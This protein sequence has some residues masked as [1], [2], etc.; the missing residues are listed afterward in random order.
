[1]DLREGGREQADKTE[2][3]VWMKREKMARTALT[4]ETNATSSTVY[5]VAKSLI[6]LLHVKTSQR[7]IIVRTI[8]LWKQQQ[9]KSDG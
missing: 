5:K 8:D 6:Y 3:I 7:E 2:I 9:I 1:M 4:Q